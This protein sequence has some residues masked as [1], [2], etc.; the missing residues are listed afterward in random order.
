MHVVIGGASGFLGSALADRLR[1][2]GHQVTALVRGDAAEPNQSSWDPAAGHVDQALIDAAD[3]VVNLSGSPIAKWP[4]TDA[5]RRELL[6]SRLGA[7]TTLAEAIARSP[8]PAAL[9]SGSG[10]AWYGTDRGDELLDESAT[11]GS[12]F[13]PELAQQWEAAAQPA[14]DAGAR[15]CWLRTSLVLDTAGGMLKLMYPAWKLGLGARLGSGEQRMSLITRD[16][17]VR[18]VE[19]L[20]TH[21]VSGPF[22]LAMR[23]SVTNAEFTDALGKAVN[24]PTFVAAPS[25]AIRAVLGELSKDLLGSMDLVPAALEEAGFEFESNDLESAIDVAIR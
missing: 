6:E 7:T 5:R 16:D 21:N 15:V 17:W 4:R 18:A 1:S 13:M 23:V 14:V 12:G 25:F 8:E 19:F 9:L 22:N 24:R 3:V 20:A 11:P 10:M 2:G